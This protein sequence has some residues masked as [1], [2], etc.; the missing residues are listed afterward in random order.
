MMKKSINAWSV[1]DNLSFEEM[2]YQISKAGFDGIELN[3]DQE[4]R[5][6]HSLTMKS[7][8]GLFAEIR[9][10]SKRYQL[11]VSSISSSLYGPDTLGSNSPEGRQKGRDF[12][13]KQLECAQELG[14]DGILVVPGG[15]GPE[16]SI[17]QA[18]ENSR[19]SLSSLTGE[20]AAG[21]VK[22]GL[23]NVWNNFFASAYDM[24]NFI[25]DL[26][27]PNI[28]AY[29]D[30]GNV[31]I[32]SYPEYWID[33]LGTRIVKIH[34]KDFLKS[35]TNAGTFVNLLEGSI[36]WQKVIAALRRAGYDDYLTAEVSAIPDHP[37]YLYHSTCMALTR[38]CSL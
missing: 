7:S 4:G 33:I 28:G 18:Y 22:V 10:L 3:L 6:S 2:F 34:V 8:A 5:S 30:V 11:P 36:H 35:G 1:P 19:E 25:D 16:V 21:N 14:A 23:E 15:I 37:E 9:T 12:V 13:R 24:R 38:I 32:F 20:I 17:Q 27:C 29:F 31:V 26:N